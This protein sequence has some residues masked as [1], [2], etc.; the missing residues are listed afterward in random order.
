MGS[1]LRNELLWGSKV[2]VT[3]G[4]CHP[5]YKDRTVLQQ[6][7]DQALPGFQVSKVW[8]L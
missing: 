5:V 6:L 2:F 8:T 4:T 3:Q 7:V 1:T